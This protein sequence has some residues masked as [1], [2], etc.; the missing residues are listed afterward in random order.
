MHVSTVL[1]NKVGHDMW[2]AKQ[3]SKY[4]SSKWTL[5]PQPYKLESWIVCAKFPML[6]C[7]KYSGQFQVAVFSRFCY[8][9]LCNHEY[10]HYLNHRQAKDYIT[11]RNETDKKLLFERRQWLHDITNKLAV[12]K[13]TVLTPTFSVSDSATCHWSMYGIT[14]LQP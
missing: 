7:S 4:I 2:P 3:Q 8:V 10:I 1:R 12:P 6:W 5:N 14:K 9:L 13:L 11:R